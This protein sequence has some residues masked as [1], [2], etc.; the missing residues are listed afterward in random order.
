MS[1][2]QGFLLDHGY[3]VLFLWVLAEQI[4]LP[5]PSTPMLLASGAL[6]GLH[7]M[8]L[9]AVLGLAA[10]ASLISDS[11]WFYL[12]K[13][14]GD[15]VLARVCGMSLDPDRCVSR[16]H[17]AFSR[18]GPES[19]LFAK[20]VPGLGTL[21]PPVAGLLALPPWKFLLLDLGGALT[22]SGTY[23]ALGWVLRTQ[24]EDLAA[25]CSRVGSVAAVALVAVLA[26]LVGIEYFRRRR[27]YSGLRVERVRQTVARSVTP[28]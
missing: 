8:N 25:A 28:E 11:I 1:S 3:S 9:A 19:L 12:G 18:Y 2:A 5:L 22:W 16:T 13:E 15:A 6:I 23:V 24:L 7:R 27:L 4:G 20:F 14:R 17:S 10:A 26:I 21:G